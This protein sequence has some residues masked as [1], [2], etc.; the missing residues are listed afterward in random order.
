MQTVDGWRLTT[1]YLFPTDFV[2]DFDL[3]SRPT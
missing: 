2:A 3:G 1:R